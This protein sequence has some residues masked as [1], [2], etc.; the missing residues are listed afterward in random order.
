MNRVIQSLAVMALAV[1]LC[2]AAHAADVH[3]CIDRDGHASYQQQPCEGDSQGEAVHISGSA[4][5]AFRQYL[6]IPQQDWQLSF[7]AP[8]LQERSRNDEPGRFSYLASAAEGLVLSVFVESSEG[9][10]KSNVGCANFYWQRAQ[11]NPMIVAGSVTQ[12]S[13]KGWVQTM[14]LIKAKLNGQTVL[15]INHNL[16]NYRDGHCIDV[17]ASHVIE[18]DDTRSYDLLM[19]FSASVQFE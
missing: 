10:G 15:Q 6:P 2:A 9:K 4:A 5:N 16:F 18:K 8:A 13:R 11:E 3:K 19:E 17:H 14:Y 1:F 12:L 7:I